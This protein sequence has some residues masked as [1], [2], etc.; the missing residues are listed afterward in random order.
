MVLSNA[1]A[2]FPSHKGLNG[3]HS[4]LGEL[5]GKNTKIGWIR[6]HWSLRIQLGPR[7]SSSIKDIINN[8]NMYRSKSSY[9]FMKVPNNANLV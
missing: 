9:S 4:L 8:R 1:S 3:S 5:A 6:T 7:N 2:R